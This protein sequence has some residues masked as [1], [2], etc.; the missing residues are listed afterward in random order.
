LRN[1]RAIAR[2]ER[3]VAT[4]PQRQPVD[5][6]LLLRDRRI[7]RRQRLRSLG[8]DFHR[9]PRRQLV[10]IQPPQN[11]RCGGERNEAG[12]DGKVN[13]EIEALHGIL[14]LGE[15]ITRAAHGQ[16]ALG[17]LRIIFDRRA[18]PRHVD[19]D[20]AVV[21][22]QR[23]ALHEVHQ[24]VARENAARRSR[25]APQGARTGIRSAF[26]RLPSTGPSA[27]CDRARADRSATAQSSAGARQRR[28]TAFS[29]ASSS[30][31]SNGLGR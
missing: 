19:I 25:R 23:L 5:A 11:A 6:L 7:G 9:M 1:Q 24:L 13:L 20:R 21:R 10:D 22:F 16:D 4:Q 17:L 26:F 12:N 3:R 28:S 18:D 31:G 29:R 8:D 2:V 14:C 15:H 27:N 30:R